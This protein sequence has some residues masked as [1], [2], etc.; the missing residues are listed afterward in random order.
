MSARHIIEL[1]WFDVTTDK[2]LGSRD[3]PD[4][5]LEEVACRLGVASPDDIY[6]CFPVQGELLAW[7][8]ERVGT[9]V[10]RDV[11]YFVEGTARQI[12]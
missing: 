7:I 1:T 11:E 12:D 10:L 4:D 2:M 6:A 8:A 3:L 5:I 9:A